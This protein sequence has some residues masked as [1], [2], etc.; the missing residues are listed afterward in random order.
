MIPQP[1]ATYGKNATKGDN[2]LVIKV[3]QFSFYFCGQ[4]WEDA[5]LDSS[6]CVCTVVVVAGL[7]AGL[8]SPWACWLLGGK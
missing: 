8:L 6:V 3:V 1:F 4:L 2:V 5:M 7:S